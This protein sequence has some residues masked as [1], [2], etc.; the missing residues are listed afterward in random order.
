ME[1][2]TSHLWLRVNEGLESHLGQ[3]K[4]RFGCVVLCET[5]VARGKEDQRSTGKEERLENGPE[6]EPCWERSVKSLKC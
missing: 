4:G 2:A 6:E 5:E 1:I 3:E